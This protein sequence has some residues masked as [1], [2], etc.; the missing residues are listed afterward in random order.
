MGTYTGENAILYLK[1][2]IKGVKLKEREKGALP[3]EIITELPADGT[4]QLILKQLNP[5]R[6]ST[7]AGD[8]CLKIYFESEK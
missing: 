8:Y 7:F 1:D 4:Y 2:R 5:S 3:L 6:A